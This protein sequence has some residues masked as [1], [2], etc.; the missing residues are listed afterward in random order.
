MNWGLRIILLYTA[1]VGGM[2]FLV[3][4]CTQQE[5]DLVSVDYY[6][7][8][9][10]FQEKIDR[11]NN[12]EQH[13]AKLAFVYTPEQSNIQITFPENSTPKNTKGEIVLFRPDNSKL[14]LK[15]PVDISEGVQNI[16]TENLTKGLWRLQSTWSTDNTPYYQEERIIIQ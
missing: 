7:Q 15:V 1:F 9:L 14:D 6:A 13:E 4:K 16:S 8:E 2:L 10:K 12:S 5:V 11:M 3:Y